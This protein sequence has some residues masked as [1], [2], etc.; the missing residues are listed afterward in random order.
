MQITGDSITNGSL[1]AKLV[2][3]STTG[4]AEEDTRFLNYDD[5]KKMVYESTHNVVASVITDSDYVDAG[6]DISISNLIERELTREQVS[7]QQLQPEMW[8]S[9]FWDPIWTRPDKMTAYLNEVV[10]KDDQDNSTFVVAEAK[11]KQVLH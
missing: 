8:E 7:S 11:K 1:Y 10:L 2:G 5:M 9:V 6:D 4:A 3:M